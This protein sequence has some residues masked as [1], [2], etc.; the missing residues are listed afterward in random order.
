MLRSTEDTVA[1]RTLDTAMVVAWSSWL[2]AALS[3]SCRLLHDENRAIG[4]GGRRTNAVTHPS[5]L[6]PDCPSCCL[7]ARRS[8]QWL[9]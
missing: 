6:Q 1:A 5:C 3:P 7:P 8:I 4:T 9:C 2:L